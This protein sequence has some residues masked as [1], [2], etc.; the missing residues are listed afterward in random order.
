[1]KKYIFTAFAA[2]IGVF[3][4]WSFWYE[5]NTLVIRRENF[6][7]SQW[8]VE[9]PPLKIAIVSDLH[10]G[11]PYW[12]LER[13]AK[14]VRAIN[15][16][17]PDMIL[18]LG[19]YLISDVKGGTY[20]DPIEIGPILSDFKAPQGVFAIL[21]NHDWWEDGPGIQTAFKLAGISV[22]ENQLASATWAGQ[23]LELLGVP[24]DSS[25]SPNIN[26]ILDN[27]PKTAG[28]FRITFTHDP[29]IY[30]DLNPQQRLDL[31]LGAHTHGGQVNWPIFGRGY[32]PGRAPKAWAHGWSKT[33]N[34]PLLVTSGVGTSIVP[35]RFRQP[36][37]FV[38]LTL[39]PAP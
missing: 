15:A 10:V 28:V 2:L 32:V 6:S 31:M 20:I 8:S 23:S 1:M 21:G 35:I 17:K 13:Q 18:L 30:T 7:V 3:L 33:K 26:R 11:S 34:G 19:D 5:Q 14:L 4:L 24:D 25:R 37:E 22:L 39:K 9:T 12:G 16:E 36:P 38:V 29:G 27:T